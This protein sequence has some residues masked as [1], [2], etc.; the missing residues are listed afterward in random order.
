MYP[1]PGPYGAPMF[2]PPPPGQGGF[3]GGPMPSRWWLGGD[4]MLTFVK[5]QPVP[6][7]IL[8]TSAPGQNGL[9]GQPTTIQLITARDVEYSAFSAFRLNGGFFGDADRRFGFDMSA[10]YTEE[11]VVSRKFDMGTPFGFQSAGIP[12]LARPF[13]DSDTGPNSLVLA[14]PSTGTGSFAFTTS[15][16]IWGATPSA[17]WNLFRSGPCSPRACSVD[18]LLGYQFLELSEEMVFQSY[19]QLNGIQVLP[20][21]R[22]GPFGVPVFVGNRIIPLPVPVGGVFTAAPAT[23]AITDIFKTTNRFNGVNLGLRFQGQRGMWSTRTNLRVGLGNMHQVLEIRGATA[24]AN[25]ITNVAGSAYGGLYA[26]ASN[27]GTVTHDTFGVI[28]EVSSDVGINLTK[29]VTAYVGVNFLY[30]NKVIRP[31]GQ[32]NPVIDSSTVPFS[33]NY[34]ELGHTPSVRFYTQEDFWLFGINFGFRGTF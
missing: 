33:P 25:P 8:T 17:I 22:P 6:F 16:R 24:F 13:I 19:T 28:P 29:Q 9:L 4:Y 26:N 3:G 32:L 5:P 20:V 2:Q 15:T 21:F 23:V 27:I 31:G 12:L 34:G 30:I 10:F 14:D 7:P 1:P 18:F 11:Q